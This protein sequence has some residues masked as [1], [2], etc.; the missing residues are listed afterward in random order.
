[1]KQ[2][3]THF[4]RSIIGYKRHSLF[5]LYIATIF[6]LR[7]YK[8]EIVTVV[9]S[10]ECSDEARFVLLPYDVKHIFNFIILNKYS[11]N[12]NKF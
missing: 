12:V 8:L 7:I 1:M 5:L 11:A 6:I 3:F 2:S 9:F 4:I 10:L